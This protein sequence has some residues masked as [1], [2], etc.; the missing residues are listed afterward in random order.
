MVASC[1]HG[2][3]GPNCVVDLLGLGQV[4]VHD[5]RGQAGS[6]C[7]RVGTKPD[8]VAWWPTGQKVLWVLSVCYTMVGGYCFIIVA[9]IQGFIYD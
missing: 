4:Q 5:D 7:M 3:A 6:S 9:I 8:P 1:Y 2:L